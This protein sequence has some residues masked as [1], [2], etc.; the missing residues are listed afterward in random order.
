MKRLIL[1]LALFVVALC[2]PALAGVQLA[3]VGQADI[4]VSRNGATVGFQSPLAPTDHS[5]GTLSVMT[6]PGV[7]PSGNVLSASWPS[8][9]ITWTVTTPKRVGETPGQQAQ[10]LTDGVA[11]LAAL[12]PP[13]PPQ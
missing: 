13:P 11:A 6:V 10:R 1:S 5:G 3:G 12:H 2:T 8:G 4:F 7:D 9:G